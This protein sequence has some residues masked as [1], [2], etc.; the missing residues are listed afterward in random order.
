MRFAVVELSLGMV[1]KTGRNFERLRE[2]IENSVPSRW[3]NPILI[4][5]PDGYRPPREE[6]EIPYEYIEQNVVA[7]PISGWGY[8]AEYAGFIN[9][10]RRKFRLSGTFEA[11]EEMRGVMEFRHKISSIPFGEALHLI[12]L[13]EASLSEPGE[14]DKEYKRLGKLLEVKETKEKKETPGWA[15]EALREHHKAEPEESEE[16]QG[17]RTPEELLKWEREQKKYRKLAKDI[18]EDIQWRKDLEALGG[19]DD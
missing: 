14:R 4:V 12:S 3:D 2:E 11:P 17:P 5:I 10:N 7:V 15:Q 18:T 8:G 16:S 1:V 19:K 6:G 9:N 13:S